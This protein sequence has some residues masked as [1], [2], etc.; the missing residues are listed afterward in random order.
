VEEGSGRAHERTR[1][2]PH[3]AEAELL[4][5]DG[6]EDRR[7][8]ASRPFVLFVAALALLAA[9]HLGR[10]L[11]GEVFVST[12]TVARDVAPWSLLA[13]PPPVHNVN[14]A[15]PPTV[16][17]P[18]Q[19][20]TRH[21]VRGGESPL[22]TPESYA[23]APWLGNMSS[24]LFSP[25]TWL[26]VLLPF[27]PAFALCAF[28]KW[29][30]AGFG[31]WLLARRLGANGLGA[32]L[33]GFAFAFCA[34]QVVWISS[35]L[36]NVAVFAPWLLL[37][38]EAVIEQPRAGRTALLA[39]VAWQV[40]VGG[41][42]ET[43]LYVGLGA[44]VF[45]ACR[46][47][48]S[49]QKGRTLGALAVAGGAAALLA[50]P[51]WL[52]FLEYAQASFGLLLRQRTP[53]LFR[54]VLEPFSAAG[55]AG[56]A[57]AVAAATWGVAL[58]RKEGTRAAGR[59][60]ALLLVAASGVTLRALGL[61][62]TLVLELLP[63][64]YG[65]SLDGGTYGGPLTYNDVTA[66]FCG[67]ALFTLALATALRGGD[68][69]V[70][71]L[72]V[73]LLVV[74][75]RLLR[76]PLV[77]QLLDA[78]PNLEQTGST[79]ALAFVAL[80]L[81]LLAALGVTSLSG[82]AAAQAPGGARG[83]GRC[84]VAALAL[85][86]GALAPVESTFA[87]AIDAPTLIDAGPDGLGTSLFGE[88]A[89]AGPVTILA[90]GVEVGRT[91][92]KEVGSGRAAWE[93][94][95][96]GSQRLEEGLLDLEVRT[97]ETI[98]HHWRIDLTRAPRPS[99]RWLVPLLALAL[100]FAAALLR[101]GWLAPGILFVAIGELAFF[102]LDYNA[103]TPRDR[104]PG[105][106]DPIPIL[107]EDRVEYGPSRIFPA[108]TAIHPSLHV[109]FGLEVMR[110]YDAL[111]PAAYVTLLRFLN[112]DFAD[113]P[114]VELDFSTLALE[115]GTISRA[116]FD[117]M[118]V[119]WALST[120]KAPGGFEERWRHGGLALYENRGALPR[121]FTLQRWMN[122]ADMNARRVDPRT[123]AAFDEAGEG[124]HPGAG[125]VVAFRH[126][127]RNMEAQVE[128]DAGTV[129]V[130]TENAAGFR[131][132]IDG[133]DA[134]IRRTHG[135]FL[136]VAVPAGRHTVELVYRPDSVARGL[137]AGGVGAGVVLVLFALAIRVGKK[138][139]R[140]PVTPDESA[141]G[142]TRCAPGGAG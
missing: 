2:R 107:Q 105:A 41:H 53:S 79:R 25:F 20:L 58:W 121:A 12:E 10:A 73:A 35:C 132:R 134:T 46:W 54:P 55:L 88:C 135:C 80:A 68:R 93:W 106:V 87:R 117:F 38:V 1:F 122:A 108:R 56:S 5:L 83:L 139:S 84:M 34:F 30:V 78:V 137:R 15:D 8:R 92:A 66:G 27:E 42:P 126:G 70:R 48:G 116:L 119:R 21:I 23:G 124:T 86:A 81:A 128:S 51:Q 69:T 96:V 22:Y 50:A 109:L 57:A 29:L 64:W 39:L 118:G 3:Y 65:R 26:F 31:A 45:G 82:S 99:L 40:L 129:L 74:G 16:W 113:V 110:G 85:V 104:M 52:P 28:L 72:A 76:V 14:L 130:V 63:D 18:M 140:S 141:R 90:N 33:A 103:T 131:A 17:L 138:R 125:R 97:G 60:G 37:A 102:G 98:G 61:R 49:G 19:W 13:P 36:T 4:G 44:A 142:T 75:A 11:L 67:A 101:P 120:E 95:W 123:A 136:S 24:A 100:V 127:R 114:W 111:E 115:P 89:A 59:A 7:G 71:A 91:Q 32:A 77:A 112:R 133:A 47:L 9:L 62:P 6:A 94:R 43:S